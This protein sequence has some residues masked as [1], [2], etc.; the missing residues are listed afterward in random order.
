MTLESD[1]VDVVLGGVEAMA[2][3]FG[4]V[5]VHAQA[6]PDV[7]SRFTSRGYVPSLVTWAKDWPPNAGPLEFPGAPTAELV[8]MTRAR[9]ADFVA[10]LQQDEVQHRV[11]AGVLPGSEGAAQLDAVLERQAR[12]LS[13]PGQL[14]RSVLVDGM[15][16]AEVWQSVQPGVSYINYLRVPPALRGSSY[17]KAS[18]A[19]LSRD[20]LARGERQTQMSTYPDNNV[21]V[22]L[23][24]GAGCRVVEL[25]LR[26]DL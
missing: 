22:A 12:G 1:S 21:M 3:A 9:F 6:T 18:M 15:V 8:P 5:A 26:K 2:G 25:R 23:L 4:G 24:Q 17:A 20:A 14:F 13:N 11:R 7:A 16:V 10:A 19:A